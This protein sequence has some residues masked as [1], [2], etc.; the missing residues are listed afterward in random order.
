MLCIEATAERQGTTATASHTACR[1]SVA[2]TTH[3]TVE[4]SYA[5]PVEA[6]LRTH[7]LQY[8]IQRRAV[9]STIN[10]VGKLNVSGKLMA[11]FHSQVRIARVPGT[12][13]GVTHK[14]LIPRISTKTL[15]ETISPKKPLGIIMGTVCPLTSSFSGG[16]WDNDLAWDNDEGWKN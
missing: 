6:T 13:I 8:G 12:S 14:S 2:E 11:V 9:E 5:A 3:T 1:S 7:L 16:Y 10:R 4:I 15:Q